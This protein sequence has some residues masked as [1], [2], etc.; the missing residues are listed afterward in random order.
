[1]GRA[2]REKWERKVAALQVAIVQQAKPTPV[3][4]HPWV[5]WV[6]TFVFAGAGMAVSNGPWEVSG[7][8]FLIALPCVWVSSILS[9]RQSSRPLVRVFCIAAAILASFLILGIANRV[10]K[11]PLDLNGRAQQAFIQHLRAVGSKPDEVFLSCLTTSESACVLAEQFIP[12]FQHAGWNIHGPLVDRVT[13]GR[14]S[15]EVVLADYGPEL[16]HPQNPDE[17]VW[18]EVLPWEFPEQSAFAELNIPVRHV[19]DPQL[20]KTKTRVYFGAAPTRTLV[21]VAKQWTSS[22]GMP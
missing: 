15:N 16:V 17:G 21:A 11:L 20:P 19:N 5:T 4:W 1:V 22:L 2:A 3:H 7:S 8:L 10:M 14:Y 18:T 13:L 12:I 6:A 9:F